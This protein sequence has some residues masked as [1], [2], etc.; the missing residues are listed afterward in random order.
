MEFLLLNKCMKYLVFL[1]MRDIEY[2]PSLEQK[3]VSSLLGVSG[4]FLPNNCFIL[5]R[6]CSLV[7]GEAL[8]LDFKAA[9]KWHQSNDG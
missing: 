1:N 6:T 4:I 9:R 2:C 3:A 5:T 8:Q 7:V